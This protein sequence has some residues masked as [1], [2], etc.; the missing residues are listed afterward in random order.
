MHWR[1]EP[2]RVQ[3]RNANGH[4][5]EVPIRKERCRL[6]G[7]GFHAGE[8]AYRRGSHTFHRSCSER[9]KELQD[10]GMLE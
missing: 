6:C 4:V 3:M 2:P 8:W 10:S 5:P 7:R 9:Y 1:T